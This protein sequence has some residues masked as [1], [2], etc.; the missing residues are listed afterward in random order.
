MVRDP[1]ADED[2][3]DLQDVLDALDDPECRA[4]ISELDEPMTASEISDASD[5]P[6]STTYRKLEL[7]TEASLLSEGVE[8]RPDG[9]HASTY[10][11]DFKEVIIGVTDNLEFDVSIARR[12]RTADERLE[13]LWSEVRKE[14]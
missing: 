7:L 5:I 10:E 6:L 1:F 2:A 12:A 13:N 9:Q 8:I 14:T 11:L 3:P 4:I